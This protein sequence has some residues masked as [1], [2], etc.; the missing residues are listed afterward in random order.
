MPAILLASTLFSSA[1]GRV[2]VDKG[3]IVINQ[4]LDSE[5]KLYVVSPPTYEGMT[6]DD[7]I[8]V[9]N[10]TGVRMTWGGE[11]RHFLAKNA[12]NEMVPGV[13]HHFDL[14]GAEL[15]FDVD[16]SNVDCSCNSAL[17]FTGMPGFGPNGQ[18]A[19]GGLDDYYC[20]ANKVGGVWCWEMDTLESNKYTMATTP[21]KCASANGAYIASCD[22][23]GCQTNAYNVDK[24][25]MC[26]SD[27]CKINT[28][29][30]FRQYQTFVADEN[31]PSKLA[32]LK[33]RFE[34]EGRVF[35]FDTCNNAD[36]LDAM[37]PVLKSGMVMAFQLWGDTW[38]KMWWLDDMTGCQ[39]ACNQDTAWT[40]FKNIQ[41]KTSQPNKL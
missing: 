8:S 18:Y 17:F 20:D 29:K 3:A 36:Y 7:K 21:H 4:G 41:I 19:K 30:P 32:Q 33:N 34:Q 23:G 16:I 35:E 14:L 13:Y 11:C 26:P 12:T 31:D 25:G 10:S 15:S 5:Q 6:C 37:S 22:R 2:L 27:K 38:Q 1:F 40:T 24:T 9:E 39:G 28:L